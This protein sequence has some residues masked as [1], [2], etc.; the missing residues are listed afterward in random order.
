MR[1]T[2]DPGAQRVLRAFRERFGRAPEIL[3]CAP[4]RIALLGAHIDYS[5]GWVMPAAIDRA[6]W[7]AASPP[8]NSI[9]SPEAPAPGARTRRLRLHALDVD[10]ESHLDLD[11]LPPP[12]VERGEDLR[13]GDGDRWSDLPAGVAWVLEHT[14]EPS[15]GPAALPGLDVVFGGDLPRGAGVSSSA[16]VEV[17]FLLAWSTLVPRVAALERL[18]LARLGQRVENDYLGVAS[19]I[20]DQCASL[21][22]RA[23]HLL[24]VDCRHLTVEHQPLG[25][26]AV[27]VVDSG[28]RRRLAASGFND[29]RAQCTEAVAVLRRTVPGIRSLRDAFPDV[30]ELHA[31]HLPPVLRRRAQH[32]IGEMK[33][34]HA[35]RAA[36]AEHDLE[37][38]GRHMR[39]SHASS[40]DLYE[41]SL[42]ELDVLAAGAWAHPACWGARLMGGGFGGCVA[43]LTRRGHAEPVADAMGDAFEDAFGHRP[44]RFV[45]SIADGAEIMLRPSGR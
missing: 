11:A 9:A 1:S 30:L 6:I 31:H 14:L 38:F 25:D 33:R 35:A 39:A 22:G 8:P 20:M 43:A 13:D 18:E 15:L 23:D 21:L 42:P 17:A 26:V 3:V 28:V 44:K 2:R 12:V 41:V 27:A 24:F 16:A 45:T 10:A 29:R 32:A 5:E 34:V 4:G 19:G 40:R 36:L 7:L 37:D